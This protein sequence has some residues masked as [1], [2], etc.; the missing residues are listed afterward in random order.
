[1]KNS[2]TKMLSIIV[3]F[4]LMLGIGAIPT[5]QAQNTNW[6]EVL[7]E[8][9]EVNKE[10]VSMEGNG[11]INLEVVDVAS[12]NLALD[13]R[14][15]LEPD[16]EAEITAGLDALLYFENAEGEIESSPM[17]FSGQAIL[18]EGMGYLFDG[19]TWY[20]ED[21]S[22]FIEVFAEE[23]QA[24]MEQ[25]EIINPEQNRE[26]TM[27]YMIMSETDTEYVMVLDPDLNEEEF[28]A[29][30]EAM[31]DLEKI[32]AD[33][34]D[35]VIEQGEAQGD[36]ISVAERQELE[37][38]YDMAFEAGKSFALDFMDHV[39]VRYSKE[40]YYMTAMVMQMSMSDQDLND[41][42]LELGIEDEEEMLPMDSFNMTLSIEMNFMNHGQNFDIQVPAEALNA[43]PSPETEIQ[44]DEFNLDEES[45]DDLESELDELE[46][47]LEE[48]DSMSIEEENNAD[49]ESE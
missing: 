32:K 26:I 16:F 1:M 13:F 19:S 38:Q 23:Y 42:M 22:E 29:D 28:W 33:A 47:T 4:T 39:E 35:Q 11:L 24:G 9:N 7:I 45:A 37:D 14:Y 6:E 5:I 36:E 2:V 27:K 17:N 31:I 3:A 49:D 21:M 12:G 8:I 44:N 18:S 10:P 20:A 34:I 48:I 43:Q 46:S 40:N 25:A 15:D 41:M 30:I